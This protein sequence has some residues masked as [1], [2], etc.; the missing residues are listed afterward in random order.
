MSFELSA[1]D[2]QVLRALIDAGK[3]DRWAGVVMTRK[4]L[5]TVPNFESL[6]TAS[7][8]YRFAMIGVRGDG[9]TTPDIAYV[10]LRDAAGSYSWEIACT[11]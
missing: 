11:A 3:T 5:P 1:E 8:L 6:P 10:C 7:A 4:S 2:E 9:A